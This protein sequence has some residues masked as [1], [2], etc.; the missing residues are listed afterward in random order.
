[1]RG[2]A[3]AVRC[4]SVCHVQ[5]HPIRRSVAQAFPTP[6]LYGLGGRTVPSG[7]YDVRRISPHATSNAGLARPDHIMAIRRID[8]SINKL[9]S[10]SRA[11]D[12][13]IQWCITPKPMRRG[14]LA[15]RVRHA[16]NHPGKTPTSAK[17]RHRAKV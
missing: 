10:I 11:V 8:M 9:A 7:T 17:R 16:Y 2:L 5:L 3:Y 12:A 6:I 13:V 14:R 1:P 15:A 4:T